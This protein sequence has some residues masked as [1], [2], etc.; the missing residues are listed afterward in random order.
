MILAKQPMFI[1]WGPGHT[2]LY[3]E[4]YTAVL[5]GKHPGAL[6]RSFLEVWSEIRRDLEPLF[7][8]VFER[9]QPVHMDDITLVMERN[10][11]PEETHFAFSYTPIR[12]DRGAVAGFFCACT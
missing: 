6:G 2:L 5:G 10:G 9:G 1:V 11:R 4:P 12:D 3:N 8:Q 7:E